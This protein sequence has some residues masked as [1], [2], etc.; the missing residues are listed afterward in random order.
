LHRLQAFQ[1]T[2]TYHHKLNSEQ[3]SYADT[4][5]EVEEVGFYHGGDV[6]YKLRSVPGIWLEECLGPA[7]E[8]D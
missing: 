6:L 7:A 4:I 2:W 8:A 5:A 3:L 1:R